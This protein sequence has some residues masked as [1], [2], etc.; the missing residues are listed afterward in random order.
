MPQAKTVALNMTSMV[1]TCALTSNFYAVMCVMIVGL[2]QDFFKIMERRHERLLTLEKYIYWHQ[3]SFL[4]F[5]VIQVLINWVPH[6][7]FTTQ[8]NL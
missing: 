2:C 7:I 4:G 8:S 3:M 5:D 6:E 1:Y